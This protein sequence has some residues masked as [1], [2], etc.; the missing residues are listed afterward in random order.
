[1]DNK[2]ISV[3]DRVSHYTNLASW[4]L[5]YERGA[6]GSSVGTGMVVQR[7]PS[8]AENLDLGSHSLCR[9]SFPA[10]RGEGFN[11]TL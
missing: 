4:L 9:L 1:M 5:V 6:P 3:L 8:L 10:W 11:S 7:G 2:H